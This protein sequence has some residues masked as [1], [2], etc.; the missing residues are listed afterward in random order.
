[1]DAERFSF[2]LGEVAQACGCSVR[3]IGEEVARGKL[4]S[5][6]IGA[7]RLVRRADLEAYIDEL[8][9]QPYTKSRRGRPAKNIV[10]A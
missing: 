8:A 1:M 7:R 2:S 4:P 9:K 3:L 6:T 5:F 10:Q